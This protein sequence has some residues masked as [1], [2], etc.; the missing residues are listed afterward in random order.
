MK[1]FVFFGSRTVIVH[2]LMV[3]I[4]IEH[5]QWFVSHLFYSSFHIHTCV[6]PQAPV[7]GVLCWKVSAGEQVSEGQLLGEVVCVENPFQPRTPI[8]AR[9]AGMW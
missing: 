5:S 4:C 8:I 6:Y 1:F 9:T 7:A 2:R 3:V